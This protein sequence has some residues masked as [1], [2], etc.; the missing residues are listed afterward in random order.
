[1]AG[2]RPSPEL[3]RRGFLRESI[4][5]SFA[6]SIPG[7]LLDRSAA[8]ASVPAQTAI[9]AWVTIRPDGAIILAIP[10]AEMGQGSLTGM[11]MVLAEE[12][13]ADWSKVSTI[14]P[15]AYA[16][17]FGNPM[18]GG[19]MATF[20]SASIRGYWDKVRLQG[21]S[22]RQVLMKAAADKWR[23]ALGEVSTK[24]SRVT[25]ASSGRS[26][27]YGDIARFAKAPKVMPVVDK[28]MLKA[29]A[30]YRIIGQQTPRLDIPA[31]T[32]GAAKYG[33]DVQVPN[34]AYATV[35]RSPVE[36]AAPMNVDDAA[37]LATPGVIRIVTLNHSVGIV[38]ETVEAAFAGRSALKV[39]WSSAPADGYNSLIGLEAFLAHA[40][41][42][43][44]L[45]VKYLV[46]GDADEAFSKAARVVSAQYSTDYAYH[47][48]M[49]PMN[50]T[51]SVGPDGKS[52]EI[53]IGTQ[54]ITNSVAL[55]A[56]TLGTTPDRIKINQLYMGGGFGRR[57]LS[58]MLDEVLPVAKA[59][60]R[61]VKLIWTREQDVQ[62]AKMRPMTGHQVDAAINADGEIVAWRHRIAG[63]SIL[64][65]G[66]SEK[67]LENARGLDR[68]VLEGAGHEYGIPNLTI[69]YLR[70]KRGVPVASLRGIGAGHNKFVVESFI[71]ELAVAQNKDPVQFR[72]DLL[73]A[74][75]R[76][77]AVI[78]AVADRSGWGQ[79]AAPGR[80]LGF[81]Y[82]RNVETYVAAVGEISFD[83]KTGEVK[84]HRFW[85]ALDPG[86]VVNPDSVLAQ[87][88]GNIVFG[89]SL[90]LKE[91]MPISDG[92]VKQSNFHDY[93]VLRMSEMPEIDIQL[94]GTDNPAKGVGE[95]ALP[96][97]APCIGNALCT[98]TGKRFRAL[99]FSPERL[100]ATTAA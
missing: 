84:A 59:V 96:L 82:G 71:D 72:L 39:E 4:G 78:K 85:M 9:G 55:A 44:E 50:A 5:L 90:A 6:L 83:A 14:Y 67:A 48:Q 60:Q 77:Q 74:E 30:D 40:G 27:T 63:E 92:M 34:M 95:A 57:S 70:Q 93:P 86:I 89:L 62:S 80:A 11:A 31:K 61:P 18:F 33:I 100:K 24:S 53:W 87:T 66:T 51:A 47:A 3:S 76:A 64:A 69:S 98:L 52:A 12:M 65:Y 15:P 54:S 1:M 37:A 10:V 17:V 16:A 88:E 20:G 49:E 91:R 58:D 38:A 94:L 29:A 73:K 79:P 81:S 13:D 25:H 8:M 36:G 43:A 21:A 23:V 68:L 45:G 26:M 32:N 2:P 22:V 46:R 28:S 41:N 19:V 75:P 7:A 56:S 99:P 97:V 42:A 35:L